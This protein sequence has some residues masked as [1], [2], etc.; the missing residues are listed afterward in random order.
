[1]HAV[2]SSPHDGDDLLDRW[3]ICGVADPLVARRP[4]S[5]EVR[6]RGG[7]ATAAGG[8]EQQLGHDRSSGVGYRTETAAS[9]NDAPVSPIA[10]P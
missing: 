9:G 8:I 7:R 6:K 5:M 2:A 1:V 3:W 10:A 4:A